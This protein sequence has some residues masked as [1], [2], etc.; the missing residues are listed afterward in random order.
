MKILIFWD[1]YWRIWRW[2]LKKELPKLKE[3]YNPDFVV[4][5]IENASSWRWPV[6][7]HIMEI[8][9]FWIDAMTGWDHILDNLKDISKYLDLP[10]SILLRPANFYETTDY[11]FPWKWY[12]I[13]E[14]NWKKLLVIHLLWEIFMNNKVDN[15][16]IKVRQ[17]LDIIK[18]EQIDSI[19]IDFHKEVTSEVYAMSFFL[20]WKVSLVYWTHTHIQTNDELILPNWT[21]IMWD[22]WMTW[23]LYSIIWAD[24]DSVKKRFLTWINKW[25]I[26]QSLDPHYV[27]NALFIETDDITKKCSFIEKIRIRWKL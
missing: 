13:F 21:W 19:I 2:A 10:N 18:D 25:K 3:K 15:P 24:F 11:I 20:D 8:K 12:K 7:K 27:V 16:F 1:I 26:E 22:I 17:I 4:A 5:N 14:K 23:P 9:S 6:E